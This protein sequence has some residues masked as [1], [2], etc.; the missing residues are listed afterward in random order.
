EARELIARAREQLH[1]GVPAPVRQRLFERVID[2]ARR[3]EPSRVVPA[4]PMVRVRGRG[5][6]RVLGTSLA[7]A[8]ARVLL[9]RAR[10]SLRGPADAVDPLATGAEPPA[11]AARYVDGRL[12][13]S[14]LFRAPAPAWSGALPPSSASLFGERPF[15][16]QSRSWQVRRWNDLGAGPVAPAVHD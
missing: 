4:A 6:A 16:S 15:S 2:E 1:A 3:A 7:F 9:A 14:A 11:S 10:H 5:V 13:Q 8:L 12:F